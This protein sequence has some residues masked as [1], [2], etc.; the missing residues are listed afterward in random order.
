[1]IELAFVKLYV[2]LLYLLSWHGTTTSY[3]PTS[4]KGHNLTQPNS[5]FE[6]QTCIDIHIA[7][8]IVTQIITHLLNLL[9]PRKIFF[10]YL[11]PQTFINLIFI[12]IF[13]FSTP[14][15]CIE[16][17]FTTSPHDTT[18]LYKLIT[19]KRDT[20]QHNP[21]Q[22]AILVVELNWHLKWGPQSDSKHYIH[23]YLL[24][25]PKGIFSLW[26]ILDPPLPFLFLFLVLFL[27]VLH[28]SYFLNPL[29]IT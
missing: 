6:L 20:T 2:L 19:N 8:L 18:T 22:F 3:K 16:N 10:T 26:V 9:Y 7:N 13:T 15:S 14:I 21:T 25:K 23:M 29:P 28:L 17:I 11:S 24:L 5:W 12:Y 1:M 27:V 4:Q